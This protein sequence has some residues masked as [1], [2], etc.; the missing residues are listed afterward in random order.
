MTGM[1]IGAAALDGSDEG[2]DVNFIINPYRFAAAGGGTVA[3]LTAASFLAYDMAE[4]SFADADLVETLT[5]QSGNARDA[6]QSGSDTPTARTRNGVKVVRF[7]GVNDDLRT[8]TLT[9]TGQ[10]LTYVT[11]LHLTSSTSSTVFSHTAIP[12]VGLYISASFT[13][14]RIR[15]SSNAPTGLSPSTGWQVLV[16]VVDGS[17]SELYV[18]GGTPSSADPGGA[19]A[20]GQMILGKLRTGTVPLDGDISYFARYDGDLVSDDLPLLNGAGS[21]LASRAGLTWTNIT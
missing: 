13:D 19:S 3:D 18:N 17:S 7:D 5:D 11:L 2:D 14:W 15:A 20:V 1:T 12:D 16:C 4:E 10:P 9:T 8:G 6:T 21:E